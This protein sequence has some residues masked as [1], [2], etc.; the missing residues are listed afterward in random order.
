MHWSMFVIEATVVQKQ[1]TTSIAIFIA[2]C[3]TINKKK[4]FQIACYSSVDIATVV[5]FLVTVRYRHG[6]YSSV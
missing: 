1:K 3:K 4:T 6:S 5:T 2:Q